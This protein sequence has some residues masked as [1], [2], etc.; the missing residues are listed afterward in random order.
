MKP[1]P[2]LLPELYLRDGIIFGTD[3][4]VIQYRVQGL[5]D[6]ADVSIAEFGG[7]WRIFGAEA[8]VN[9]NLA[10][11]YDTAEEAFIALR[12]QLV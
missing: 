6:G 11:S 10:P 7:R 4:K 1:A 2:T 9:G 12:Y 3:R 5:P 8:A